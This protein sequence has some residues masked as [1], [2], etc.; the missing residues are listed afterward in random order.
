M[1]GIIAIEIKS[2]ATVHEKNAKALKEIAHA[3]GDEWLGGMIVYAG[4]LIHEVF[5]GIWAMPAYR[6]FNE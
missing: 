6:L 4:D 1:Q 3:L 2:S 5:A